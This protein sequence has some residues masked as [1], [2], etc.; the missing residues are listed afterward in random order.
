VVEGT[1]K[2]LASRGSRARR[3]LKG[4]AGAGAVSGAARRSELDSAG[5]TRVDR[6]ATGN[7][8]RA[9]I[10]HAQ[11]SPQLAATKIKH[12][13]FLWKKN[14]HTHAHARERNTPLESHRLRSSAVECRHQHT[15]S[16]TL[17]ST[18]EELCPNLMKVESWINT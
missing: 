13:I 10:I 9:A 6:R 5:G 15:H 1:G 17:Q 11:H 7:G 12:S 3:P 8:Y 16:V 4:G 2:L 14:T 18:A